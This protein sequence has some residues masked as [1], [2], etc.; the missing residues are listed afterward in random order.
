MNLQERIGTGAPVVVIGAG[1]IGLHTAFQLGLRGLRP[2]IVEA[3]PQAGGQCAALYPDSE[4]HDAPGFSAIR[5]GDVAEKLNAQL[6]PFQPLRLLGRRA[7]AVWGTL[8]GGFNVETNTGETIT[9]AAVVFATG[10]GAMR[11]KRLAAEGLENIGVDDLSYDARAG[12][13]GRRVAVIGDGAAA[14][15]A[16]LG[17]AE[18]AASVTLIHALPLRADAALLARLNDAAAAERVKIARGEVE[19]LFAPSGRLSRV[20]ISDGRGR[21]AHDVDLLLVQAGL[22]LAPEG[23]TGLGPVAN[24]ATGETGTIGVFIVGDALA[25]PGRPPVI[26]LGLSEAIRAADAVLARVAPGAARTLPH[27]A[28]SPTLRARLDRAPKHRLTA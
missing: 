6:A 22:E 14:I 21:S 25:G 8:A 23:V 4:I 9:G 17:A 10:I 13:A 27:T 15:D 19:R 16:A 26:G 20:E 18:E 24:A 7:T 11:P 28:S 12:A 2:A 3:L 1:P 5:A